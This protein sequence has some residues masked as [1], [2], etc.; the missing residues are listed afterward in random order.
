MWSGHIPGRTLSKIPGLLISVTTVGIREGAELGSFTDG[1][2][3]VAFV[4]VSVVVDA[5][6]E[7]KVFGACF[8]GLIVRLGRV[9]L[10]KDVL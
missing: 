9:T 3:A 4:D 10:M 6:V 1:I 5:G 7:V 8:S 2:V